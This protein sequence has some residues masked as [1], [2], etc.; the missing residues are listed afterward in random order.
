MKIALACSAWF[1][2]TL[3][4]TDQLVIKETP[5]LSQFYIDFILFAIVAALIPIGIC[6]HL[7]RTWVKS[8]EDQLP[9]VLRIVA[10]SQKTGSS[11]P[12]AF[13]EA[14]MRASGTLA[15]ELRRALSKTSWGVSFEDALRSFS[16]R[17]G[18]LMVR[19]T[20]SLV[21]E[22][23]KIGGNMEQVIDQVANYTRELHDLN[24]DRYAQTR[25]Y[26][27]VIYIG[28]VLFLVSTFMLIKSFFV[29]ISQI[30][31]AGTGG[32]IQSFPLADFRQALFIMVIVQV[33]SAGLVAGKIAEGSLVAGIKH[34]IILLILAFI[35]F[36]FI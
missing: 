15:V 22:C 27:V 26:T 31:A 4:I 11:L 32:L 1:A 24:K 20:V 33:T 35:S 2:A 13:E 3:I 12:R 21:I 7:N 28:V 29:P 34:S 14:S 18:T 16:K 9:E 10:Q 30:N 19:R 17:V 23:Y 25:P 36:T 6:D 5:T 8:I